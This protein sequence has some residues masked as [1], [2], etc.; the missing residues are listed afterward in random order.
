MSLLLHLLR[1]HVLFCRWQRFVVSE[2]Q[3]GEVLESQAYCT[4]EHAVV[5]FGT[6]ISFHFILLTVACWLCYITREI[7]TKFSESKYVSIA[8]ISNFQILVIGGTYRSPSIVVLFRKSNIPLFTFPLFYSI[9]SADS[10]YS[11]E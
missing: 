9:F 3:F 4:S 1:C 8:M 11:V 6:I 7:P 10:Y 5:F 2:D